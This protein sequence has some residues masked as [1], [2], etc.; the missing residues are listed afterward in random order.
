[1]LTMVLIIFIMILVNG[2][3]HCNQYHH[4]VHPDED[5]DDDEDPD[6]D[7]GVDSADLLAEDLDEKDL[8]DK[9]LDGSIEDVL[10]DPNADDIVDHG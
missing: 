5:L 10:K 1:M 8:H 3:P 2:Y 4:N 9:D 6:E 7:L